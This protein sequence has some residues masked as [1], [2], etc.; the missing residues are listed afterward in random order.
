MSGGAFV[1]YFSSESVAKRYARGRPAFHRHVID[2]LRLLLAPS[3]PFERALDVGCGTGGSTTVL[4]GLA[5]KI[6]G[7]DPSL[8]M[9]LCGVTRGQF[10]CVTGRGENLPFADET[11]DLLTVS[12]AFHWFDRKVFLAEAGRVL[13]PAG[14]LV[15]YDNYFSG[16][17]LE[18]DDLV[19]WVFDVYRPKYPAPP[20]AP[21]DFEPGATEDRFRCLHREEYENTVA[22]KRKELIEY[23]LTQTNVIAAV[24][25]GGQPLESVSEWLRRELQPFF[26]RGSIT[27][28]FG[29]PIWILIRE[30]VR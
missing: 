15:V 20:R 23:L 4:E 6:I 19:R 27:I 2:R 24:E 30:N 18:T 7:V 25:E 12:S 13:R 9:L 16:N 28:R 21:V 3:L 1:N 11:F 26:T 22:F 14:I 17:A 10:A 29:G 5:S 8:P